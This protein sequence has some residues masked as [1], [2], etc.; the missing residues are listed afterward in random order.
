MLGLLRLPVGEEKEIQHVWA[1]SVCDISG[2]LLD[3]FCLFATIPM[4]HLMN[5]A[6]C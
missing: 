4:S 2:L 5:L 1:L 3:V 6:I